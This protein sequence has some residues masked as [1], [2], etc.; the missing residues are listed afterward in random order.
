ML[1]GN[2][3]VKALINRL[4]CKYVNGEKAHFKKEEKK[5]LKSRMLIVLLMSVNKMIAS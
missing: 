4:L 5:S 1:E 3:A 2:D